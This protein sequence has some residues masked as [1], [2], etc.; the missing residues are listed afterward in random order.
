MKDCGGLCGCYIG[1]W[2]ELVEEES[3]TVGWGFVYCA[4]GFILHIMRE[5][6]IRFQEGGKSR[7]RMKLRCG[8][9]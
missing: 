4:M 5:Y 2:W 8:Y 9:W 3:G 6:L 7:S 1:V